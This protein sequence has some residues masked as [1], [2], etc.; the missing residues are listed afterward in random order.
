MLGSVGRRRRRRHAG[1]PLPLFRRAVRV[2]VLTEGAA[3]VIPDESLNVPSLSGTPR[4]G[5]KQRRSA[6]RHVVSLRIE[7]GQ[8]R[9][10]TTPRTS[11]GADAGLTGADPWASGKY[12]SASSKRHGSGRDHLPRSE[13]RVQGG[14]ELSQPRTPLRERRDQARGTSETV[15]M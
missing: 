12:M 5:L 6:V 9:V 10:I 1:R 4:E 7:T 3:A 14:G 13:T 2:R 15:D 11:G 8:Y